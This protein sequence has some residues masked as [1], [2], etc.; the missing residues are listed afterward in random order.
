M[1]QIYKADYG[2]YVGASNLDGAPVANLYYTDTDQYF[3]FT[4]QKT[5]TPAPTTSNTDIRRAEA[6][7]KIRGSS[8]SPGFISEYNYVTLLPYRV[9]NT[10]Y[11]TSVS[12]ALIAIT[13]IFPN[14]FKNCPNLASHETTPYAA[15]I[16]N[17]TFVYLKSCDR[18]IDHNGY[19]YKENTSTHLLERL[20]TGVEPE[21]LIS[22]MSGYAGP[23]G[24]A[25][26]SISIIYDIKGSNFAYKV[27]LQVGA[28]YTWADPTEQG[29]YKVFSSKNTYSDY[30]YN[31]NR[32]TLL[33]QE[34][35][36]PD[37]ETD[38]DNP[39][40]DDPYT[41]DPF[42]DLDPSEPG[43]GKGKKKIPPVIP[44][45]KP[46]VTD[47]DN[48]AGLGICSIYS[49][50]AAEVITLSVSLWDP[51]FTQAISK[52]MNDPME[53]IISFHSVPVALTGTSQTIRIGN[54]TMTGCSAAH[55]LSQYHKVDCGSVQ[56]DEIYGGYLD[57]KSRIDL[58]LPFI[59]TVNLSPDDVM[60]KTVKLEYLI[61]ILTG[62]CVATISVDDA[63]IGSFGGN[64]SYQLPLTGQSRSQLISGMIGLCGMAITGVATGGLSAPVAA[65]VAASSLNVATSK[66]Q[67][68]KAGGLGA[69]TGYIGVRTPY[70]TVHVPN[71]CA[72]KFQNEFTGYPSYIT[73]FVN[74]LSG[75]VE[76][77]KGHVEVA[78]ATDTELSE[79]QSLLEAGVVVNDTSAP[80]LT[81]AG[82]ISLY[83]MTSEREAIG[84][85]K[86]QI[87]NTL[88]GSLRSESNILTPSILIEADIGDLSTC[89]YFSTFDRFYYVTDIISI[90]TGVCE[91]SGR[92]DVLETYRNKIGG[93]M[94]I[95][96]RQKSKW[97]LY[98]DDGSFITYAND[99]WYTKNF[100]SA[101]SNNSFVLVVSGG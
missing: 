19:V 33:D 89:N 14:A 85:S 63:I 71:Q 7:N 43:G 100:T 23:T 88:T 3:A 44:T 78:G 39:P 91:I 32:K 16:R 98:I 22:G 20:T 67:Y 24:N 35:V 60:G 77:Y 5:G 79:I 11:D 18:Y 70:I 53:A 61:D 47:P 48:F 56:I 10:T 31:D 50:T 9:Y 51:T 97:N 52:L 12:N 80:T 69:N 34:N 41:G 17:C 59:G 74:M 83:T 1:A 87:G 93:N 76:M 46:K 13:D 2:Y 94:I 62:G 4:Q 45:P 21:A 95:V 38:P 65:G 27:A 6:N 82:S 68:Q 58:F 96:K 99:K 25:S 92:V 57:Y 28:E 54:H 90:R 30:L 37:K 15:G 101:F 29:A 26:T 84:K 81:A 42:T 66:T 86:T 8:I 75:Y 55:I 40:D 73:S 72:P 64:C 49:P 36:P